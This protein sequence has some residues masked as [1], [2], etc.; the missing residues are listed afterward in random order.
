MFT[1]PIIYDVIVIGG[2]HAGCE[3]AHASAKM[4]SPTLL[5]TSNLDTIGKMSCNPSIGGTAKGHIVK[6]IDALGGIMGKIADQSAIQYRMLNRSKGAAVWSPRAQCDKLRYSFQMKHA[7]ERTENLHLLQAQIEDFVVKE[8]TIEGVVTKEGIYI[9]GSKVILCA[10]TFMQG[11]IHIGSENYSGGRSG[12]AATYGL[13]K[14]LVDLGFKMGRLKTGTPPRLLANSIDITEM[15][16][17]P[18]EEMVAFSHDPVE[19]VIDKRA[20]YITYT[21]E[22]TRKIAEENLNRSAMF[23]GAISSKGPRYCPSF[24]DKVHRFSHRERHQ[25]FL[26]PEGLDTEEIYVNG[27]STSLPFD[28]QMQMIQSV[29]GMEK[30][31]ITRPGYA[32]EYDIVVCGQLSMTLETKLVNGLY[33]AGQI[34]G[35]T[36]YEEAAAQGLVAAVN[37]V[38]A[39]RLKEPFILKRSDAYIGVLIEDIVTKPIEEPYRMFTSRAEYRLLLRQDNADLRLREIGYQN[40]LINDEQYDAYKRK[41]ELIEKTLKTLS[42]TRVHIDNK[43]FTLANLLRRPD[44]S[45]D[46][47]AEQHTL[48]KLSHDVVRQVELNIKYAGY[49]DR[50]EEEVKKLSQLEKI[51][52]SKSFDY[53]GIKGLRNEAKEVLSALKPENLG[54][55]SRLPQVTTGDLSLLM[56]HAKK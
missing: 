6:E 53:Q 31:V 5:V 30:A 42:E 14:K 32:I 9:R 3:A 28:V 50:Q 36:G 27:I 19:K 46:K 39:I 10:G 37:A 23:S 44:M 35:T 2:G 45:Y 26:E 34:N 7:L 48:P 22:E 56:V 29:P 51:L 21:T 13:S 17:Q 1:Y 20:C 12:D 4:G 47:L 8:G 11:K 41:K 24:E 54:I 33:L 49:L 55:V 43:S 15:E 52:L 16:E 25:L 40:G 18:S 38:R